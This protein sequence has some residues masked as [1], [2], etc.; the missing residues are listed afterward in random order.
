MP[1][2][3]NI[4]ITATDM[5]QAELA[6]L[7]R[8][9]GQVQ[10]GGDGAGRSMQSLGAG[11]QRVSGFIERGMGVLTRLDLVQITVQQSA[12]RVREAQQ[13]YAE[14]IGQFGAASSQAINAN[15]DLDQAQ[16]NATKSNL[17][18]R[19]SY[20][21][22]AG[23]IVTMAAGIPRALAAL[24]AL[25]TALMSSAI[26]GATMN[27]TLTAGVAAVGI[28]AGLA[29]VYVA[30]GNSAGG[31][32]DKLGE[33]ADQQARLSK[34][35]SDAVLADAEK[36][37]QRM[38]LEAS[39][40][41]A[42]LANHQAFFARRKAD[43]EAE[44]DSLLETVK[45]GADDRVT[46]LQT[47]QNRLLHVMEEAAARMNRAHA[48]QSGN[49]YSPNL[50]A[51]TADAERAFADAAFAAEQ[52]Q[53]A[54]DKVALSSDEAG[55][56]QKRLSEID[57]DLTENTAN[58]SRAQADYADRL[59][60]IWANT[61]QL[62]SGSL[63]GLGI[64]T[65]QLTQQVMLDF[66]RLGGASEDMIKPLLD[67]ADAEGKF[68]AAALELHPELFNQ[69]EA[70]R[71]KGES[72]EELAARLG[73][74]VEQEQELEQ[75]GRVTTEGIISQAEA[76]RRLT[77]ETNANLRSAQSAMASFGY[78]QGV[79][80]HMGALVMNSRGKQRLN[81]SAMSFAN[82][83]AGVD[84]TGIAK[85]VSTPHGGGFEYG[86]ELGSTDLKNAYG[87]RTIVR[88]GV[89]AAA[90]GF[91]GM[92]NGPTLFLAGEAGREHVKVTPRGRDA[93]ASTFVIHV[94]LAPGEGT[95]E[96]VTRGVMRGA[97]Q[98][99]RSRQAARG[100]W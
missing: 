53:K 35:N 16:Q 38:V 59:A 41:K 5:S 24:S 31:A 18:A 42:I 91:D 49:V 97:D 68:R 71:K 20:V 12:D 9:L 86:G 48:A 34:T 81:R 22:V 33:L 52:N 66:Y 76:Q 8:N 46:A 90:T 7:T 39:T 95:E 45:A 61:R 62:V 32:A 93:G 99:R 89:I 37:Q 67:V 84:V 98:V 6:Q 77:G 17:R 74:T 44:H 51:E 14:A 58:A 80:S 88:A 73:L 79:A 11:V 4:T 92:V 15:R 96:G 70:Q 82:T 57:R 26:A 83:A 28:V 47:E 19:L 3:V 69:I 43:L 23:D 21:L 75:Q 36:S 78:A 87:S 29:A 65:N 60:A 72:N 85:G 50:L 13:K 64:D 2:E 54:L 56:A 100:N 27:I 1:G 63:Q 94:H 30:M 25:R 40:E 10:R 55:A